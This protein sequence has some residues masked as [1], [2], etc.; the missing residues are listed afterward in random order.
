MYADLGRFGCAPI[1][2]AWFA[3]VLPALLLNYFGQG[4]LLLTDP[5]SLAATQVV[6]IGIEIE[7]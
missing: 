3:I 1:H 4:G 2:A 5:H 7:I 6:E